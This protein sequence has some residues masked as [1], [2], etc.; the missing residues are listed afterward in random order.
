M[1]PHSRVQAFFDICKTQWRKMLFNCLFFLF[2]GIPIGLIASLMIRGI[3][4]NLGA[5]SAGTLSEEEGYAN[6][7]SVMNYSFLFLALAMVMVSILMSG[8]SRIYIKLCWQ[9]GILYFSDFWL[10]IKQNSLQNGLFSLFVALLFPLA[11]VFHSFLFMYFRSLLPLAFIF[12]FLIAFLFIPWLL[13]FYFMTAIYQMTFFGRIKGAFQ[14][15]M[16]GYLPILGFMIVLYAPLLVLIS[17]NA[18]AISIVMVVYALI[19][20][21]LWYLAFVLLALK[22]FDKHINRY[23]YPDLVDR[24]IWRK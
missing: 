20:V 4:I 9:K 2:A 11:S 10:G 12:Y 16:R 7:F 24:G 23:S 6:V 3:Y 13:V 21:P 17:V 14:I 1:L 22:L 19:Y 8:L 18:I 15:M 5:I